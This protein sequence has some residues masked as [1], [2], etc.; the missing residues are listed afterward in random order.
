MAI[1]WTHLPAGEHGFYRAPVV[2]TGATD[3][4]LI[5]GG[6]KIGRAHV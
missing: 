6:F 2:L 5:D 3:A 4:V 1:S